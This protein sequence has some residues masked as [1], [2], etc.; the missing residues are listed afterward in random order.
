MRLVTYREQDRSTKPGVLLGEE[1]VDISGQVDS[2]K[3]LIEGGPDALA[4]LRNSLQGKTHRIPLAEVELRAPLQNPPRIFCLGLAYRDHAIETHQEIPK[5]PTIFLKLTSALN[6]P[7]SAVVLPKRTQ[8]PD[9]EAEFAFVIG[10]GGKNISAD[11]WEEHIFGY[12]IMNDVSA[13]DVQMAT[14]QWSLGKSFDTFAPL[15]PAI[16]TKDEV[17]DPHALD[18]KLTIGG[19]VLQHSNTRELIFRVP[20]I[21]AYLSAIT[22]LES[23]DIISTGTPAGVGLGRT[24]HRW[25]RPGETI[26]TEVEGLGQLV[27]SVVAEA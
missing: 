16:V 8:Q 23:G 3:S 9:Y 10:T 26:V 24:P 1:I 12:T 14:S 11:A 21:I 20:D 25:L 15:G 5:V 22:S 2:V 27:N 6:G 13:R 19:E 4:R 18:I 7:R 17:P